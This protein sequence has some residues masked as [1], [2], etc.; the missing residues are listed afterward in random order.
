M[1]S[2]LTRK[3]YFL[4][5]EMVGVGGGGGGGGA[6]AGAPPLRPPISTAQQLKAVNSVNF[7]LDVWQGP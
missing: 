3:K 7:I 6:R 2:D 1:F 5:Q 4:L